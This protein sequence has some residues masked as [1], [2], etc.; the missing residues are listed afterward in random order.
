MRR[1]AQILL[2]A[3][4]AIATTAAAAQ[5]NWSGAVGPATSDADRPRVVLVENVRLNATVTAMDKDSRTVTL[6]YPDGIEETV[7][8]GP[9]V[10]NFDQIRVGDTV[11]AEYARQTNIFARPPL[12]GTSATAR[13]SFNR[14]QPGE[15]PRG[16][17]VQTTEIT[18]VI[19]DID[20]A[21]RRV[22]LRGPQGRARTIQ[23]SPDVQGLENVHKGDEVVIRQTE[24]ISLAVVR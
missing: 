6:R 10:R 18:A 11:L 9:E 24:A 21:A 17:A 20:Q 13:S 8:A 1:P 2:T 5:T 15:M 4:L 12:S 22:T 7:K 19:E 14:A 16:T 3:A 23:V